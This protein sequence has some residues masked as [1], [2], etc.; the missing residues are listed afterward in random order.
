MPVCKL[1]IDL[2]GPFPMATGQQKFLMVAVDYFGKWVEA[3]SLA[4][5]DDGNIMNFLWKNFCCR[6]GIPSN[7]GI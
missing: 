4:K 6:F 3:M 5:I 7:F 1:G 2:V